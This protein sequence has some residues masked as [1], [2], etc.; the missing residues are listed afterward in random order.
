MSWES[1]ELAVESVCETLRTRTERTNPL[2]RDG[3]YCGGP[4]CGTVDFGRS[5]FKASDAERGDRA[6]RE[7]EQEDG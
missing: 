6:T 4:Y 2:T 3:T 5:L 7:I 1:A